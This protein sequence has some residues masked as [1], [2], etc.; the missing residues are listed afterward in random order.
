MFKPDKHAL[1]IWVRSGHMSG[2]KIIDGLKDALAGN[3]ARV[4]IEGQHWV[5]EDAIRSDLQIIMNINNELR[6]IALAARD[7]VPSDL[8]NRINKA[9]T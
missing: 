3:F 9:V 2:K 4:T 6:E 5:R 8:L 7:H 1:P